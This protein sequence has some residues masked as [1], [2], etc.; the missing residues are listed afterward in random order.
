MKRILLIA[1]AVLILAG[2]TSGAGKSGETRKFGKIE[3]NFIEGGTFTMGSPESEGYRGD[4][5]KQH[6]VT[7]SSFWMGKY[8]VTQ[9]QYT[10][11]IGTNPSSFKSDNLPVEVQQRYFIMETVLTVQAVFI[12]IL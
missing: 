4:D 6:E 8:E 9:K 2:I 10:V 7:V 1:G 5:E 3:F 12:M 11:I